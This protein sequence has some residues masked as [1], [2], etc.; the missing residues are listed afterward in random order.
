MRSTGCGARPGVGSGKL[1]SAGVVRKAIASH[2]GTTPETQRMM[3]AGKIE[4]ELVP[5][6]TPIEVIEMRVRHENEINLGQVLNLKTG[7]LQ[8]FDDFEPFRPVWVNE[9]IDLMRLHQK[10]RVSDP[11]DANFAWS[12]F[13]KLRLGMKSGPF[14]KERRDENTR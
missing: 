7:L 11:G 1:I 5:Q 2:I 9:Q 14:R 4:V 10:R 6:G 12:N 3:L 8:A 13:R